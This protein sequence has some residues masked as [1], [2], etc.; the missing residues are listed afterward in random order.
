M[1]NWGNDALFLKLRQLLADSILNGKWYGARF[2]ELGCGVKW[3]MESGFIRSDGTSVLGEKLL[4]LLEKW[5]QGFLT[6]RSDCN[7]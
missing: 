1:G 3:N 2:E 7:K 6:C 4:M 5:L